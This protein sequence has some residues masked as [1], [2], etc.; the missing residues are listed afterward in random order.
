MSDYI[1]SNQGITFIKVPKLH[2]RAGASSMKAV[3]DRCSHG[4]KEFWSKLYRMVLTPPNNIWPCSRLDLEK[5]NL[6]GSTISH[7]CRQRHRRIRVRL[8]LHTT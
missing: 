5:L 3:M 8:F 7:Y 6:K 1:K 2:K 4:K